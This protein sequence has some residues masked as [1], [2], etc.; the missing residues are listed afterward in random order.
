MP[1]S[2]KLYNIN[3][4]SEENV[5]KFVLPYYNLENAQITAIKFKNTDKQRAVYRVEYDNKHYCLK[6][7]YFGKGELLFIYSAIEWLYRNNIKVPRILPNKYKGRFVNYENML[8][9]LTPWIDGE[10]CDYDSYIH[11]TKTC[12]TLALMHNKCN[13]FTPIEGSTDRKG[14]N[15]LYTSINKHFEQL[16][17]NSNLAFKYGDHF[18]K[19]YLKSFDKGINLAKESSEALSKVNQ[20]N[21]SISL[22]HMDYVNKNL[23]FDNNCNI[24][25]IDFDK[26]RIDYTVH[27]LS[28]YFRRLL[29]RENTNWNIDIALMCLDAYEQIRPLNIDEYNYLLGYLAFPQRYWKISRDYYRNI[30]KCNKKAFREILLKSCTNFDSQIKFVDIFKKH[31]GNK[32]SH[33]SKKVTDI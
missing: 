25:I 24:W 28:Y 4:L 10:K 19:I 26:C 33:S 12:T 27:D 3:L 22:C 23:I 18:S 6:K 30:K 11:I 21:L 1:E 7:V 17:I 2:A 13:N 20:N 14:C 15:N 9:I 32:F 29:K 31:I 16:L 8:F 5:K